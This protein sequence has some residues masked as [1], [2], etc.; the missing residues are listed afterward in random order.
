MGGGAEKSLSFLEKQRSYA[1]TI[2][3]HAWK[4][5]GRQHNGLMHDRSFDPVCY[6]ALKQIVLEKFPTQQVGSETE[7]FYKI[8]IIFF[9]CL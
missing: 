6:I 8:Y 5:M 1:W 4:F 3:D 2:H 7:S 9:F